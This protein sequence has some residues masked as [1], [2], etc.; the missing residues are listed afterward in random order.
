MATRLGRAILLAGIG[1][2]AAPA[3]A[4]DLREALVL[5]YNTNPTLQAARAQQRAVDAGVAVAR[6]VALPTL[7]SAARR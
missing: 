2:G 7:A 5:A 1:L 4:D 3:L 6:S